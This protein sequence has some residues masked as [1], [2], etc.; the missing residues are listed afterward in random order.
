MKTTV[1]RSV[2]SLALA[3]GVLVPRRLE[4]QPGASDPRVVEGAPVTTCNWSTTVLFPKPGCTGTLI[5]PRVVTTAAH[6]EP[7]A[8]E[9]IQF[10]ETESAPRLSVKAT[11]CVTGDANAQ[12]R[13]DWAYCV[14][15]DD[16]RLKKL[17]FI[18]P[19][20]GCEATRFL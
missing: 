10:G 12:D 7:K 18:P 15:P 16:D 5:H 4:A 9:T 20:V 3:L 11:K 8:N 6:C 17:P 19:L 14:L 2:V 13:D 1:V